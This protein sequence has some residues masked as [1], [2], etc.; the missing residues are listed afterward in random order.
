MALSEE[1]TRLLA[2]L[3]QSLAAEDPELASTLR[4]SK[5]VA[6]HRRNAVIGALGAVV[7]IAIVLA[8]AMTTWTWLGV[9]GFLLLVGGGYLFASAWRHGLSEPTPVESKQSSKAP[10]SGNF[11]DRMEERWNRRTDDQF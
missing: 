7:G 2:Q 6:R 9:I 3:E 8:G 1:E 5:L 10:R 4:G 11:V